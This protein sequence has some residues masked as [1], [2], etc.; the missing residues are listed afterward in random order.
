ML[1]VW[2][3]HA[4]S[5][6]IYHRNGVCRNVVTDG[7]N[8]A[9]FRMFQV[10]DGVVTLDLHGK[11]GTNFEPSQAAEAAVSYLRIL[12][13]CLRELPSPHV[14]IRVWLDICLLLCQPS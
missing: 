8:N 4:Y 2:H 9:H 12:Q 7:N 6:S 13:E 11:K 3:D 5:W 10:R 14:P 1:A